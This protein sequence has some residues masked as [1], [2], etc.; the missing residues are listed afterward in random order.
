VEHISICCV[1]AAKS[2]RYQQVDA[3]TQS[4]YAQIPKVQEW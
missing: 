1:I 2:I 4:G 3:R